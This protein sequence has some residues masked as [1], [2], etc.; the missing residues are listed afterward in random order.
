M[1]SASFVVRMIYK[2]HVVDDIITSE[3]KIIQLWWVNAKGMCEVM[4]YALEQ[5][6]LMTELKWLIVY[7]CVG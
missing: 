6:Q 5:V 3:K 7:L 2:V 4:A 1:F